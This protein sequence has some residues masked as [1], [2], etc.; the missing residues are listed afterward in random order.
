METTDRTFRGAH[1]AL[2]I[3]AA[4][5]ALGSTAAFASRGGDPVPDSGIEA[6]CLAAVKA[7]AGSAD[8]AESYFGDNLLMGAGFVQALIGDP[9]KPGPGKAMPV[10]VQLGGREFITIFRLV[11]DEDLRAFI[12]SAEA[13]ALFKRLADGDAGPASRAERDSHY[14]YISWEIE[15]KPVT[16]IKRA[17]L[18]LLMET[19]PQG[20]PFMIDMISEYPVPPV[21]RSFEEAL[22][23]IGRLNGGK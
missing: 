18:S 22:A 8:D 19:D 4:V 20:K 23:L 21:A 1:V 7:V 3:L 10:M 15:G 9:T 17:G 5:L 16:V 6:R 12:R 2:A 14:T 11:S 13:K